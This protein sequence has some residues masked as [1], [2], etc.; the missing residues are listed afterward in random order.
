MLFRSQSALGKQR[1]GVSE[2]RIQIDSNSY[3]YQLYEKGLSVTKYTLDGANATEY[4]VCDA[5]A[6]Q[7][8]ADQFNKVDHVEKVLWYGDVADLSLPVEM[9][10]SD[11]RKAFYNGDATLMLALFDNTTSSDEAMNA[12]GEM[13]KIASKQCFIAGM[14]GVV[15]DIKNVAMKEV[16]IYVVI[17]A[18]LSFLV[19]E[20]TGESFLVPIFFLISIGA[21]IVYNLGS[22]IFLG[23]ICYVTKA[24]TA[25]LQLGVTM[26]YSIF[27]LNSYEE[28]KRRF[29]GDKNRAMGHAISNT[30]KSIVGSSVT[31]VAGFVALCVMTFALGR[32][33]GIVMAKGVLIGVICCVTVL[34][35]LVLVFDKPIEKTKHKLLLSNMDKPSAFITKHYK[36]WIV[37]FLV[38][39]F[40]AIYGNNHTK[41]YYD[42]ADSLPSTLDSNVAN[43]ELK[44]DFD[45]SNIHMVMLDRSMDAKQ[46]SKMFDEIDSVPGSCRRDA[47]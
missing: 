10:P 1:T 38:L 43:A 36:V 35:S 27:L 22:N 13:R 25:V 41:I 24:L 21:A 9:I 7:K 34:P 39:L 11:L 19:L 44:K 42:I 31:T 46:K 28:N 33:L 8:L 37:V 14:T 2:M 16:P 47:G 26:D 45:M 40:P 4:F 23:E 30:F 17:A 29:P 5:S 18:I 15:A 12:V 32:D 6:I 20:I 3:S